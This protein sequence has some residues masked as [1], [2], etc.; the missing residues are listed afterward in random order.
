M[1]DRLTGDEMSQI[2]ALM[3]EAHDDTIGKIWKVINEMIAAETTILKH[4][5]EAKARIAA[6]EEMIGPPAAP[7]N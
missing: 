4:L 5:L 3:D 2:A 7:L 6:L 1:D